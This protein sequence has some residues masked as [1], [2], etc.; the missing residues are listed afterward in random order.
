MSSPALIEQARRHPDRVALVE[1]AGPATYAQLL[2]RS[3]AIAAGL[4]G[5]DA[6][7]GESRVAFLVEPGLDWV[8][9]CWG[10]WRAGGIAVPLAVS[11]PGAELASLLADA[12]PACVVA[13]AALR[14]RADRA[15]GSRRLYTPDELLGGG[16]GSLPR[17][18][19]DRRALMVY[20]SG[21]TG[22][23]KGVVT[24]HA[25]VAAQVETLVRAWDWTSDDRILHVLPLHHVHGIINALSCALWSGAC[26]EFLTPFVAPSVW[27]R[28]AAGQ[29]SLF[30]AVPTVYRRLISAWDE[31]DAAVRD[32]WSRGVARLRLMVSGSAALP[33][34]TLARWEAITGHRLLERYGMTEIGMGL[35]NPLH[36]ERRASTVGQPFPGV[37]A[38]IVDADGSA[39]GIRV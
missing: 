21:T 37:E 32:R 12:R 39:R 14:D 34:G 18:G 27:E 2:D 13:S 29:A 5:T 15:A 24:T 4:L 23:P 20:T 19:P 35:G 30:M 31:A 26:C 28:L 17:L 10:I 1:A 22:R 11:Y 33:V 25:N 3:A 6:D 8:A 9:T 7:L 38:R 16:T 36:G